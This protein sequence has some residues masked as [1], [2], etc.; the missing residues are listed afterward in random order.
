MRA[1]SWLRPLTALL[2]VHAVGFGSEDSVGG[3]WGRSWRS[4]AVGLGLVAL[5]YGARML[6][7]GAHF[8]VYPCWLVGLAAMFTGSALGWD[9]RSLDAGARWGTVL[10]AAATLGWGVAFGQGVFAAAGGVALIV[11]G[12]VSL[13]ELVPPE[14]PKSLTLTLLGASLIGLTLGLES[15]WSSIVA[16][17]SQGTP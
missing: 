15:R 9:W 7:P 11:W 14:A 3:S 13:L 5:G 1:I 12:L 17:V 4:V 16:L 8:L 6:G 10:L 2:L